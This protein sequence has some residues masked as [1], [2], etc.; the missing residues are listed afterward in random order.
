MCLIVGDVVGLLGF[1]EV[2][3]LEELSKEDVEMK[4]VLG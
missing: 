3:I 1:K 4:K 2:C